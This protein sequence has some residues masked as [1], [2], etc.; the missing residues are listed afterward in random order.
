MLKGL[1]TDFCDNLLLTNQASGVIGR[2][3]D[4][5]QGR[6]LGESFPLYIY[7]ASSV[8]M[9]ATATPVIDID[10]ETS[11]DSSFAAGVKK[12]RLFMGLGKANFSVKGEPM[13]AP[14]P[15]D[16]ARYGRIRLTTSS[17]IACAQLSIGI[18]FDAQS[19]GAATSART[20]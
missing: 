12:H 8:D 19:N 7:I 10:L 18:S 11:D 16:T 9:T 17:T 13:I 6:R 14:C 1:N 5:G 4:F 20:V 15:R 2:T 3:L